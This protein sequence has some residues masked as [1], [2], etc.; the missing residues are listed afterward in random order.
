MT[1]RFAVEGD[2]VVVRSSGHQNARDVFHFQSEML[3][4]LGD[5]TKVLVLLR[6]FQGWDAAAFE[7]MKTIEND[8]EL[9][10][11]VTKVAIV[12]PPKWNDSAMLMSFYSARGESRYF[13]P[14]ATESDAR[15][16]LATD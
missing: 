11:M 9:G 16:W 2:L 8:A 4:L 14:P 3:E 13:A 5:R 6:E 10:A 15:E 12:G 7:D 1:N